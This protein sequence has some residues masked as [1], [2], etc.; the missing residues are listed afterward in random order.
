MHRNGGVRS[1]RQGGEEFF[2]VRGLDATADDAEEF[3]IRAGYF[4]AITVVQAP[5]I[6]LNTGSTSW[7]GD[8]RSDLKVLK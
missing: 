3:S 8:R 6:R 2:E 1:E 5:V 7:S 4:W